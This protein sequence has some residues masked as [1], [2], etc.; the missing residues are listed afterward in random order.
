MTGRTPSG[1]VIKSRSSCST[2]TRRCRIC[3]YLGRKRRTL[4][5]TLR[6]SNK[7]GPGT[8]FTTL[9]PGLL[10]PALLLLSHARQ[11]T[12]EA[13]MDRTVAHLNFEHYRKLLAQEID[14][15]KR[16]TILRRSPSTGVNTSVTIASATLRIMMSNGTQRRTPPTSLSLAEV[17]CA[18]GKVSRAYRV[19]S[20]LAV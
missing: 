1:R 6:R 16:Q 18:T 11:L 3:S 13:L 17:S 7:S 2:R 5:H 19:Q 10:R 14:E 4:R 12:G 20:N 9:Q 8:A 15:T